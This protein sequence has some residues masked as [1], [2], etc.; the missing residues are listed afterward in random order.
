MWKKSLI[1]R[2]YVKDI[3]RAR[4]ANDTNEVNR[5]ESVRMAEIEMI[6]EEEAQLYTRQL[7]RE[8]K[9]FRVPRP[10]IYGPNGKPTAE[11]E[12]GHYFG[13][14]HLTEAGIGKIR[15]EIRKEYRWQF[16]R[17]SQWVLWF[18]AI[19]G[20]IGALTGLVAILTT[21]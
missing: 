1:D 8:A 17:R 14:W 19:T 15:K 12:E 16:E 13:Q 7:L 18:T 5:L 10:R 9:R 20:I 4:T 2:S 21:R 11:W 6:E 3:K